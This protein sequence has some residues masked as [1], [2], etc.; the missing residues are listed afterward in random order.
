MA[1]N[2]LKSRPMA[3]MAGSIHHRRNAP[4]LSYRAFCLLHSRL[5]SS[6]SRIARARRSFVMH[7]HRNRN[8]CRDRQAGATRIAAVLERPRR[9]L[10]VTMRGMLPQASHRALPSVFP[11]SARIRVRTPPEQPATRFV[12]VRRE[13][14]SMKRQRLQRA[15]VV[16]ISVIVTVMLMM[17]AAALRAQ[18]APPAE[19]AKTQV[20]GET[21]AATGAPNQDGGAGEEGKG[22]DI[23]RRRAGGHAS[24]DPVGRQGAEVHGHGRA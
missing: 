17:S 4:L 2:C 13:T 16:S 20:K 24:P 1:P 15:L 9:S 14:R 22:Q 23:V 7:D 19:S 10:R 6:A 12:N 5:F 11:F 21:K 3:I 18:Q 8:W